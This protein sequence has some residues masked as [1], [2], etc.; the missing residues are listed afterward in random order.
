MKIPPYLHWLLG[1][2]DEQLAREALEELNGYAQAIL[3]E[4][5]YQ[6]RLFLEKARNRCDQDTLIVQQRVQSRRAMLTKIVKNF[7]EK[8]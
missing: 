1:S 7:S 3:Q 6:D 2:T 4:R 8:R 5:Q